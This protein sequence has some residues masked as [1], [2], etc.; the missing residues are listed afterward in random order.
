MRRRSRRITTAGV[1]GAVATVSL[2]GSGHLRLLA[3]P[4]LISLGSC[5]SEM[6]EI[7]LVQ[8]F[9]VQV[10]E[11]IAVSTQSPVEDFVLVDFRRGPV[12]FLIAYVGNAPAFPP[13]GRAAEVRAISVGGFAATEVPAGSCA[14]CL[15]EVLVVIG[16]EGEWPRFVHFRVL[17]GEPALNRTARAIIQSLRRREAL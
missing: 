2:Q 15:R 1:I 6:K 11:P 12:S 4:L 3:L 9:S 10:L 8:Q 14:G 13:E 7:A 17:A 16:A 5:S